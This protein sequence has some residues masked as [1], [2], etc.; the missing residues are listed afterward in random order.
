MKKQLL[1][2]LLFA[3]I[4]APSCKKKDDTVA[5]DMTLRTYS[6]TAQNGKFPALLQLSFELNG[7][8]RLRAFPSTDFV[9]LKYEVGDKTASNTTLRIYGELD[10]T[11]V[12]DGF[13]KGSIID[14][15]NEI[16]RLSYKPE[17]VGF[18][19]GKYQFA[20]Y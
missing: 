2:V 15:N 8:V 14:W 20:S 16:W 13:N 4:M 19:A 3:S 12:A 10:K 5:I 17:V 6:A 11:L 1:M 7:T 9:V 18:K